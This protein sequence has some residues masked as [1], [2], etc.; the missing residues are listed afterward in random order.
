MPPENSKRIAPFFVRRIQRAIRS[1]KVAREF[2]G[3]SNK[4]VF[5]KI[6]EEKRWGSSDQEHRKYS[7]GVGTRDIEVV[8][9]Y[10][11]AVK[12]F[13]S[14]KSDIASGLDL[15]CGDFSVGS[16]ICDSFDEF[17]AADVAANVIE[18]NKKEFGDKDARFLCLNL[19]EDNIP[20]VDVIFVRQVLQ[21]LSNAEIK[22]F[23]RNIE[24]KYKYLI[25]TESVS[26]SLF[27]V[28]NR[29]ITTGPGIRIHKRS[30]VVLEKP[31]FNIKHSKVDI[32]LEYLR[33]KELFV[34]KVY[35]ARIHSSS[36]CCT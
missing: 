26:K 6:Y 15:G 29:D 12:G 8:Q 4:E 33:G 31:P 17:T 20:A 35:H 23:V 13:I 5:E 24:G 19:A 36:G 22:K 27:F 11:D 1:R 10:I 21:H 14:Q 2:S 7:S 9:K 34:T 32:L 28:P 3:L 25:V 18:E 16:Q 30:G